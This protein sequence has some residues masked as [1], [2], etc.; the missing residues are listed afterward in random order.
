MRAFIMK[1]LIG[2]VAGAVAG[3]LLFSG[4][5]DRPGIAV[6]L[7][8]IV[9]VGFGWVLDTMTAFIDRRLNAVMRNRPA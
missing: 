7:F 9:F 3:V 8:A 4:R 6:R 1:V 2:A 5:V